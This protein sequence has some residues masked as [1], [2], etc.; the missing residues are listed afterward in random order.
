MQTVMST[1]TQRTRGVALGCAMLTFACG[2]AR[3][4]DGD[5]LAIVN[6][7]AI[8]RGELVDVL[9]DA[10]GVKVLQQM[11]VTEL[12][13]QET[14]AR[15]IQVSRADVDREYETALARIAGEAGLSGDEDTPENR[16]HALNTVLEQ[17]CISM[18]EFLLGMERNAHLRKL[19]EAE[20]EVDEDTLREEFA[21]TYGERVVVRHIQIPV[22]D[23][24]GLNRVVS[25]LQRGADFAQVARDESVN[26]ETAPRGGELAPF[27]FDD[28]SIDP[29]I[30]E[31][32]FSLREGEISSPVKTDRYFHIL[33]L[34]QRIP[35]ENVRFDDVRDQVLDKMRERIIPQRMAARAGD[36]FKRA[37]IKVLDLKLRARYEEFLEQ[38]NA[39]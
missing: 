33:K 15:G 37:K 1:L 27:T 10:Y 38:S 23:Q 5:A 39:E 25:L 6:G 34:E 7:R 19:V 18:P 13:K 29:L 16:R 22:H 8:T 4:G 36:L 21:R 11:I 3:G 26:V 24:R 31:M 30:R 28:T 32:A 9:L 2:A 17:K 12:A 35:P 20:F 14:R